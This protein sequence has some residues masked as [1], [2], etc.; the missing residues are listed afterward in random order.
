MGMANRRYAAEHFDE[1]KIMQQLEEFA[2][3]VVAGE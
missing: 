1:R 2:G 3:D